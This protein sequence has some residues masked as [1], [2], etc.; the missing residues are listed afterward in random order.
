MNKRPNQSKKTKKPT[1]FDKKLAQ[2]SQLIKAG[3]SNE[4]LG[5]LMQMA[6]LKPKDFRVFDLLC[7]CNTN[8]GRHKEAMEAGKRATEL[9]PE[10]PETRMRY[11]MSLQSGGEFDTALIELERALYRKPKDLPIMRVK[12]N[13]YTDLAEHEKALKALADIEEVIKEKQLKPHEVIGIALNKARL[14]PKAIPAQEV[15]DELTPLAQ[16][17]SISDGF[18][19]IA[20]H[21]LGRL[22]ESLKDFDRSFENYFKGNELKKEKWDPDVFDNYIDKLIKCWQHI[23]K[24][25]QTD[26]PLNK[27]VDPSRLIFVVGMMRS[28]TSM[29]EQ[30]LAQI[31]GVIPGGELNAVGRTPLTFESLPNPWGGRP[32]PVSRLIYNQRVINEMTKMASQSF[33]DVSPT[34]IITDKQPYNTFYVPLITRMFPGAKIIHCCRDPQ[35]TCLSNFVQTF[36]RSHPQTHDLYWMGRYHKTY[37]RMMQAWHELPQIDMLDIQYED[38]VS[39]P[40]TQSKKVCE[41]LGVTWTQDILNFHKSSR[42]VR[43]ASRDQVRKPIYKSSVKKYEQFGANLDPLRKGLGIDQG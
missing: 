32:L 9:N 18:R 1:P 12:L 10:H 19:V 43:T 28:G 40:E 39:D 22:Y 37:Q 30:M 7:S 11:A 3:R 21:H 2:A 14:C 36:A 20:Y 41:Y 27:R 26:L 23:D 5:G 25:P 24:V 8:M 6:Q 31:P 15:I 16:D 13:I 38:M 42:T 4:A 35:D 34:G 29:T 33:N 17:T